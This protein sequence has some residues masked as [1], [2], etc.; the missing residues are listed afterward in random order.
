MR[1]PRI[2]TRLGGAI[3]AAVLAAAFVSD[4]AGPAAARP[5]STA[6]TP[7]LS[8]AQMAG[9]RIIYSYS[10]LNPP[11]SLLT[12]IRHGEAAGVIFFGQNISSKSQ[13][14]AVV[15]K[16][17]QANAASTNPLRSVPLLLMTD[18][19]GGEVRR[20]PGAPVLSEK[21]IGQSAHPQDAA[22]AAGTGAGKNLAS[23]GMTV[24]LA[25]VLDVFRKP[26]DFDDQFGRSYSRNP[27]VV[28]TLG[29]DF[30]RRQQAVGVA[31]TAKH[32]PGLGAASASQNTDERAVTLNL[33]LST[34]R[35]ID[36]HPYPEAISSGVKLVM[37]SW[38]IYPALDRKFPAGLSSAIISGE[39]RKRLGFKGVTITDAL[40]AGALRAFGTTR[41]R[42]LLAAGAGMD[43]IL[44]SAQDATQ[45]EQARIQL[46]NSYNSKV[47]NQAAF[48][49]SVQRIIA[50]R[51]SLK[52]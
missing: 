36:E 17:D 52:K 28:A 25:P 11:A 32:F 45:G 40:E 4:A 23:V 26:G 5:A 35:N 15:A 50:L 33:K 29:G 7:N 48:R 1:T 12:L 16:L 18:Q 51:T 30:I 43:L 34:I 3:T 14:S 41:H 19:E 38:A 44:C 24:N 6:T 27:G 22:R 47:L 39:L 20:L 42:A 10:G 31:A 2:G 8:V 13:I 21:Q 49:A 9:Q 46:Q 37:A